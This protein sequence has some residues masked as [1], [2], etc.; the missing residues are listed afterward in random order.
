MK[1]EAELFWSFFK[2]GAFTLGGGYAMIPL[3]QDEIVTKKKWL[4]DEEFLDA[5]AIAQSSPG[6]LAVNTSIMTGYRISGRLGI[7]AAVLGA[8]LP[9]FL[10]I[11]CLSTVIIQYREAK[12]FQQV[13]FGVKPAT[14]GLIFIAVYKLCKSTKLNWTHYWIPLL[15]AVLVGMNFMSP[16]WIIICTMIIGNL[17]YAWRDKK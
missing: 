2:I 13:F 15:V 3:M 4:T 12:L 17:Y 8:V 7:A 11:L 5:L 10:I 6:V 1:K 9:S 14:V 16:V